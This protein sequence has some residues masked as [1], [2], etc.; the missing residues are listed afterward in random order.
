[1]AQDVVRQFTLP[2]M[3]LT[4]IVTRK[5]PFAEYGIAKPRPYGGGFDEIH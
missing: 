2:I 1:M 4:R 3:S 5:L